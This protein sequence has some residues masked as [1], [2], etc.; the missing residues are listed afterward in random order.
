MKGRGLYRNSPSCNEALQSAKISSRGDKR[1]SF[2]LPSL[3]NTHRGHI[4]CFGEGQPILLQETTMHRSLMRP[5]PLTLLALMAGACSDAGPS[6][7]S[8]VTFNLA[9]QATSAAAKSSAFGIIGTPETF[10]DGT[11]TLVINSVQLVLREIE[12]RKAGAATECSEGS[13][14]DCAELELGPV[15]VDLPMGTAGAARNFSVELAPGSYDKVEFQMH[16][17]SSSDD[18][19]FLSAHPDL[20]DASVRVTGTYNGSDFTYVGRFD[21]EMEFELNPALIANETSA[22][23]LT[24]FVDLNPWFR[25]QGGALVDPTTANSGQLNQGLVEQNI[26]SSLRAFEDEDHDG[27]DDHGSR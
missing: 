23:D 22:T 11:N 21:A 2:E 14:D 27:Q 1:K 8:Q 6:N 4:G 13:S 20:A 16:K 19:A 17:L 9:T 24:L 15:L 26:K 10:T 18:G 25:N 5:A 12:L 7:L 3:Q